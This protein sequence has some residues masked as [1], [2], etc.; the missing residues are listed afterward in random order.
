MY[1]R[2]SNNLINLESIPG[3][4]IISENYDY[5]SRPNRCMRSS[6]HS[7]MY[8]MLLILFIIMIIMSVVVYNILF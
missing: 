4:N 6:R 8:V 1:L 7:N 5:Y 2:D 3:G